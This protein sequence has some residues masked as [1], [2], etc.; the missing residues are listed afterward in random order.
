MISALLFIIGI[1][2]IV[3][4]GVLVF[5]ER[6]DRQLEQS[7]ENLKLFIGGK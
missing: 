5:E 4:V 2:F 3:G 7:N 1:L 6:V